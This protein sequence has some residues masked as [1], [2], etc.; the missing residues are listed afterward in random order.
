MSGEAF[1]QLLRQSYKM[2]IGARESL[3]VL[4][5]RQLDHGRRR[6]V[7]GT[8]RPMRRL[9]SAGGG[10][11]PERTKREIQDEPVSAAFPIEA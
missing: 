7:A 11:L 1:K 4:T 8:V 5:I 10:T 3:S 2:F 9:R 6:P